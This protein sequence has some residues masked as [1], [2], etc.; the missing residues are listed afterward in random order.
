MKIWAISDIHYP[1]NSINLMASFGK[2]WVNH[3]EQIFRHWDDQVRRQDLIL[4]GGDLSWATKEERGLKVLRRLSD[5]PGLKK[6]IIP[7]NHDVW[8]KNNLSISDK[9]PEDIIPLYGQAVKIGRTVICGSKG[10]LAPNDP[11]FDNLDPKPFKKEYELLK[12]GLDEAMDLKPEE[13]IH[14]ILHFPPFTTKGKQTRFFDLIKQYPII[15]CSYG[16][17]HFQEEW[18]LIPK[19]EIEGI[20][21]FLTSSDY[22]RHRPVLI[23]Q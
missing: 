10:W 6:I 11:C 8:W 5:L 4:L 16:H 14:L 17:F 21:C 20:Q 19:G 1:E 7:G 3:I 23:H 15:T 13:G 2:F 22:L 12:K 18:D 9:S